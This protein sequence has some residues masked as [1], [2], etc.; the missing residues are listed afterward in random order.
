MAFLECH[1]PSKYRKHIKGFHM[2]FNTRDKAGRVQ[3]NEKP[4][5]KFKPRQPAD[6]IKKNVEEVKLK[7][8]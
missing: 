6:E 2:A 4:K 1:D 3:E 7:R 8:V 5:Y